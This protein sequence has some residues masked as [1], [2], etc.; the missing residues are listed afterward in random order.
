MPG[1][2]AGAMRAPAMGP[3]GGE[4]DW[5]LP[6]MPPLPAMPSMAGE[7]PGP[8]PSSFG[9]MSAQS[10]N[11]NMPPADAD[12]WGAPDQGNEPRESWTGEH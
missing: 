3:A 12:R 5:R 11:A 10:G 2:M 1:S 7:Q 9:S 4:P 8:R 6:P